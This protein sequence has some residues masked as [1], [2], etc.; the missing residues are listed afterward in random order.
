MAALTLE[1]F[2]GP[3]AV[4]ADHE[5]SPPTRTPTRSPC[6]CS[7]AARPP[8]RRARYL[9]HRHLTC[10]IFGT[11]EFAS[12]GED[13]AAIVSVPPFHI[14]GVAAVLSQ[15]LRRPAHRVPRRASA[16]PSWLR[17]VRDEGSHPRHARAH[18]AR[19]DRRGDGGRRPTGPDPAAPVVRRRQDAPARSSAGRWCCSP[20]PASSTRTG[21]PR[22]AAPSPCSAPTTTASRSTAT[23]PL[24]TARLGSVGQPVPGIE[25]R[26]SATTQATRSAPD[27][28]GEI[29]IRGEQVRGKYV[30]TDSK[31]DADGWFHTGDRGWLDIEGYVFC[32]GRAD[33]T[34]IRGGENIGPAEV[35]DVLLRARR[36]CATSPWSASRTRN[37][38]SGSAVV[39]HDGERPVDELRDYV[40]G[41]LRGSRTPDE[42]SSSASFPTPRPESCCAA[43]WSQ[44]STRTPVSPRPPG[45]PLRQ[46]LKT[47]S[48]RGVQDTRDSRPRHHGGRYRADGRSPRLRRGRHRAGRE[49]VG[50]GRARVAAGLAK[51]VEKGKFTEEQAAQALARLRTSTDR[52]PSPEPDS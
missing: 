50:A 26:R 4:A 47:R 20:R 49:A 43:S 11:V 27:E 38:A 37:G 42:S 24:F 41:R 34:I 39:L 32:E 9:R 30:G 13:E 29:L 40:R 10:R 25:F 8:P 5:P 35:E 51:F 16:R 2:A 19:Q 23:S 17:P 48:A 3:T 44:T 14:A 7:R 36:S 22:P 33:D 15:P 45:H 18:H 6:C 46:H 52:R 12:A 21:S 31:V 1:E 28:P